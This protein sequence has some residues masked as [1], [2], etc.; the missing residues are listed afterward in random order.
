MKKILTL[1]L[2]LVFST[3][4]FT[5]C[6]SQEKKA[7]ELI[8]G[9]WEYNTYFE[10]IN[11]KK[12][13]S[14]AKY[15]KD[16]G[17]VIFHSNGT[18]EFEDGSKDLEWEFIKYDEEVECYVYLVN[19]KY[20]FCLYPEDPNDLYQSYD[21]E[22][23]VSMSEA[24]GRRLSLDLLNHLDNLWRDGIRIPNKGTQIWKYERSK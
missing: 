24:A 3:I 21:F 1:I 13:T 2:A 5:G 10:M 16:D 17:N 12:D 11:D 20:T 4:V 9:E 18:M 7:K 8:V 14:L 22:G 15:F 23:K 19:N 6:S